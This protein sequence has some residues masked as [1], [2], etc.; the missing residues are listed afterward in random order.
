MSLIVQDKLV[1]VFNRER[2]EIHTPPQWWEIIW[3]ANILQCWWKGFVNHHT[4]WLMILTGSQDI[5]KNSSDISVS[6]IMNNFSDDQTI[7][8][9]ILNKS[10]NILQNH[11]A[12]PDG[13]IAFCEHWYYS[14]F[15]GLTNITNWKYC[16]V[17]LSYNQ[18]SP[19][20]YQQTPI[21]WAVKAIYELSL[22]KSRSH[23]YSTLAITLCHMK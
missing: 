17:S 15:L 11:W 6:V 22:V 1:F 20:Y 19:K 2:I 10:S 14:C 12:M 16:V 7:C 13:P 23:Q 5:L 4:I 9:M 21:G 18:F 8:L 3:N